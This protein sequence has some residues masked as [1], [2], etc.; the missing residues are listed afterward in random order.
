MRYPHKCVITRT[1]KTI[2]APGGVPVDGT[3]SQV[4]SGKCDT[5]ENSRTFNV[6]A[7][8]V[9]SK[10]SA[11]VFLPNGKVLSKGISTGDSVTI[12]WADGSTGAGRIENTSNLD[13]TF[14][15]QY[16]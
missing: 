7:G 13:D 11:T 1:A 9:T 14:L 6:Q 12:T 10:G 2:S 15:V 16:S 5:Q 3:T 8:L 4:Y